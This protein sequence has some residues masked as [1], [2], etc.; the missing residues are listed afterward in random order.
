MICAPFSRDVIGG[1]GVSQKILSQNSH[2]EKRE[3]FIG[4]IRGVEF[5]T[6]ELK[7]MES[8]RKWP[9]NSVIISPFCLFIVCQSLVVFLVAVVHSTLSN[10]KGRKERFFKERSHK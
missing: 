3:I 2:I 10:A 6:D 4:K 1:S 9:I 8:T 5:R 7:W